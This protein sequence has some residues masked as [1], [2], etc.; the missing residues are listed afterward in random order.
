MERSDEAS[1]MMQKHVL[2]DLRREVGRIYAGGGCWHDMTQATDR[3]AGVHPGTKGQQVEA[4]GQHPDKGGAWPIRTMAAETAG[5][6][7]SRRFDSG[8]ET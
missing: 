7:A 3:C 4:Y 5:G 1:A 6:R 8:G 2:D